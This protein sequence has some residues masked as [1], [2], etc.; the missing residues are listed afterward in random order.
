MI[1]DP[2]VRIKIADQLYDRTLSLVTDAAELEGVPQARH[3]KYPELK[4]PAN[5]TIHVFYGVG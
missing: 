3:K 4:V 2:H 5:A 1:H